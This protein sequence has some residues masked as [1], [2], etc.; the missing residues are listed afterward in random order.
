MNAPLIESTGAAYAYPLL[1]K[2]LLHAPMAHARTQEIVY[3]DLH[4]HSY[5]EL[6]QRIG[7]LASALQALGVA[8]GDTVAMMDWDS[9]RY[10]EA[11]FAVPMMGATLMTV[12]VRLSNEKIAHTL[13]HA[14][15]RLVLVNAEFEPV[16]DAIR[17]KLGG[18]QQFVLLSDDAA[19]VPAAGYAGEYEQLL[20]NSSPDFVFPDFDENTRATIFY[21][22]GTTGLPKG[23]S[24]SHRQLVLHT[25]ATMAFMASSAPGQN[26]QRGDVYMPITPM[27]HVHAWGLP[28]V[29]TALGLKQVY[30]GRYEPRLLLK[31]KQDEQ[32][33]FSHCV[34]TILQMLLAV[35]AA[36]G[37]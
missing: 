16:L 4:R 25:L 31:L 11:Y 22:T 32:V 12:N 18:V 2:Q 34:P 36:E 1:I 28:Y 37:R 33:S 10:L 26:L 17:D 29:A 5:A 3:R 14:G 15:A 20:A 21:T 6:Q 7:R 8:P 23:V 13:E 35:P 24:F 19:S 30:P 27:F 9:H